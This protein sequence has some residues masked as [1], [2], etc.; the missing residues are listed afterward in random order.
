MWLLFVIDDKSE[1]IVGADLVLDHSGCHCQSRHCSSVITRK[2]QS[3][4][5][6]LLLLKLEC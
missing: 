1:V 4:K 6:S 2:D 3:I 5:E